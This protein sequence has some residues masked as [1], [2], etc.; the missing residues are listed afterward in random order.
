MRKNSVM[1]CLL[2]ASGLTAARAPDAAAAPWADAVVDY[3]PGTTAQ[4][5]YTTPS[6]AL[7]SPERVTGEIFGFPSNVTM[8]NPPFG[9]DEIVSIGEGGHLT[10]HM[11]Q[12]VINDPAHLYGVDLIVFG[13]AAFEDADYPNGQQF[14]PARLF[15]SQPLF[16]EVSADGSSWFPVAP[17]A[18]SLFPTQ[19][20]LDAAANGD[21]PASNPT[22]FLR[23]VNPSLTL[24]DFNGLS[25][26]QSLALYDGSGG[27]TPIDIGPT[28]MASV[29]FVRI[30]L[31][32]DGNPATSLRGEIDAF[33]AVPEP[34][35]LAFIAC[36][37]A[38]LRVRARQQSSELGRLLSGS[39]R[40]KRRA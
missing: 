29:S 22:N 35:S 20:F 39:C 14:N 13:K 3:A 10:V 7:G 4:P 26:A 1:V 28:G 30:S 23:P 32:D 9:N 17:R 16:V 24:A 38:F 18:N 40:G 12:P 2:A 31:P 25:Y 6:V 11:G 36:S 15:G 33:A 27:G 8:F 19:G 37:L 34:T 21:G 5:G